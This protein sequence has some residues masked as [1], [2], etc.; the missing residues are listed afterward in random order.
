MSETVGVTEVQVAMLDPERFST[1]QAPEH[2]AR[3]QSATDEARSFLEGRIVW[4]INSTATGGGVAEMLRSLL[5]YARGAGVD[6]RWLVIGGDPDF[7][8]LTKRL[9]NFLHGAPGDGGDLGPEEE[10]VYRAAKEAYEDE[11]AAL[12][13]ARD[14]VI[15]HDPQ[16][17]ALIKVLRETGATVLWRCH[18]G[19]DFPNE[20]AR[21]AW[22][23]LRPHVERADACIFSRRQFVWEGLEGNRIEIVPPSIDAFSPKNQELEDE[24]VRAIAGAAG[25][26]Q[27]ADGGRPVFHRE[28][29]S[30]ATVVRQ[31]S[32]LDGGPPPGAGDK[33]VVQV[34]RWDRLKDPVGVIQG[35]MRHVA[36]RVDDAHLVLAGPAVEAVTDDPEGAEVVRESL[37]AWEA[38]PPSVRP[39]VHLASLPM[40]DGEENGAIVNALQRR[41][42][43]VVQKSLAEGFGLTVSEGMWKARPVVASR[44]G[45]IQDQIVDGESGILHDPFDLEAHGNAVVTLLEDGDR[46]RAMGERAKERVRERFLGPRHLI[47]YVGLM[48]EL[49]A[50][51]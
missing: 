17:A 16:P 29:G 10:A 19:T 27:G 13:S 43:V 9:H 3:L 36:D 35:F 21:K 50:R 1:I 32:F 4:N 38:L 45:G 39:R 44:V 20:L 31:A 30:V 22:D 37:A 23:F 15:V 40:E 25:L 51:K 28:D 2:Y 11:L 18:I 6:A 48:A 46:A 7:F 33:I 34:S 5:A 42:D 8:R 47:Q 49:L 14:V 26:L 24:T 12:V 41:A